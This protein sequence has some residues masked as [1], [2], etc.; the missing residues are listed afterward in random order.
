MKGEPVAVAMDD[1]MSP[2]QLSHYGVNRSSFFPCLVSNTT[3][4]VYQHSWLKNAYAECKKNIIVPCET[5]QL[6]RPRPDTTWVNL[7]NT[8]MNNSFCPDGD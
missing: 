4:M 3:F 8:L 5:V 1:M 2:A 7:M 6:Y